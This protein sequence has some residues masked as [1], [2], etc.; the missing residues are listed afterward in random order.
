MDDEILKGII[1]ELQIRNNLKVL[2]LSLNG[3]SHEKINKILEKR[4]FD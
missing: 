3:V 1:V 2:E 4:F